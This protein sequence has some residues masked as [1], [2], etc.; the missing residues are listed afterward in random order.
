LLIRA[1]VDVTTG[2]KFSLE[3]SGSYVMGKGVGIGLSRYIGSSISKHQNYI[4]N[5][6]VLGKFILTIQRG[7]WW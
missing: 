4:G 6:Y 2:D 3:E 5:T 7:V 1:I